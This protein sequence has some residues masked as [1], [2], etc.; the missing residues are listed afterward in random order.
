MKIYLNVYQTEGE[1]LVFFQQF[2]L[3][4]SEAREKGRDRQMGNQKLH[5]QYTIEIDAKKIAIKMTLCAIT[6][7]RGDRPELLEH[8]K[9]QV[10]RMILKPDEH[11]IV[12]YPPKS[13]EKDLLARLR[14]G[15]AKAKEHGHEFAYVIEDDDAYNM[16]YLQRMYDP[17]FDFVGDDHTMYYSLRD[18]GYNIEHHPGRASLFTT[19]FRISALDGFDWNKLA[20]NKVFVDIALWEY[21]RKKRLKRKYVDSGAVGIKH[22]IGLTGG[23][24]HHQ[25]YRT[26][27]NNWNVLASKVDSESLEFYKAM[28]AKLKAHA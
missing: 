20:P 22:G 28:H 9:W 15:I 18:N 2:Y 21:A 14:L 24:G 12:D 10:S 26:F 23:I 13:A 17:A 4:E 19:G 11:I 16:H 8:C 3:T 7:T 1:A 27:D 25:R 6:P 5:Y